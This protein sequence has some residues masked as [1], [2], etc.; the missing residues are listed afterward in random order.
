MS[1]ASG[2]SK[3][4]PFDGKKENWPSYWTG[5]RALLQINDCLEAVNENFESVL[6]ASEG[7]TIAD[8]NSESGK[9]QVEA[10]KKNS[11]AMS[12]FALTITS[13]KLLK[14]L[15]AS[16]SSDWPGGLACENC[17]RNTHLTTPLRRR[18]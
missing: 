1:G 6:P 3:I 2:L 13:P 17:R 8:Q 12:L 10:K 16:K 5:I 18:R 11:T 14:L 9:L 4:T 7:A 15:E